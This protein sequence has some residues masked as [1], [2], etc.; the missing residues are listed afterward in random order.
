MMN[1]HSSLAKI[2]NGAVSTKALTVA[3]RAASVPAVV[4][5]MLA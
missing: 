5:R 2:A 3:A 4:M 1:T